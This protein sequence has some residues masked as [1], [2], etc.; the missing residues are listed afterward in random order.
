MV[1]GGHKSGPVTTPVAT[2]LVRSFTHFAR[3]L[4]RP[5]FLDSLTIVA[6]LL[7]VAYSATLEYNGVKPAAKKIVREFRIVVVSTPSENDSCGKSGRCDVA[8]DDRP[9]GD[10]SILIECVSHI[11][12]HLYPASRQLSVQ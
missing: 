9:I 11:L 8:R 3:I 12:H 4:A 5:L 1:K 10:V 6:L 7:P 2:P